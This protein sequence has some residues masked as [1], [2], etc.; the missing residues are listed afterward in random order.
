VP[1]AAAGTSEAVDTCSSDLQRE[2]VRVLGVAAQIGLSL[3]TKFDCSLS[4]GRAAGCGWVLN[5]DA[6]AP[7]GLAQHDQAPLNLSQ[8]FLV[9]MVVARR[10]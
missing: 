9:S 8:F 7:M 1:P 10:Q 2:R 6:E 5:H 3:L 4:V